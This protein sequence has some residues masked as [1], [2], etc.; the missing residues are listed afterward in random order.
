ML[1]KTTVKIVR[2]TQISSIHNN[3]ITP[4]SLLLKNSSIFEV[5]SFICF[6][7]EPYFTLILFITYEKIS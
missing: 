3:S 5:L 2:P 6:L 4:R 1:M 7:Y